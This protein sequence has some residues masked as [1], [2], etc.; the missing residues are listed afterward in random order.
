MLKD[1]RKQ[2]GFIFTVAEAP[3]KDI[4]G[5]VRAVGILADLQA[6]VPDIVLDEPGSEIGENVLV[7]GGGPL[8]FCDLV[9]QCRRKVELVVIERYEIPSRRLGANLCIRLC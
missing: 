6:E 8:P 5:R 7:A 3:G 2:Q 4:R 1:D 9:K